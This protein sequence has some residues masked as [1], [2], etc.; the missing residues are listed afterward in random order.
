MGVINIAAFIYLFFV[1]HFFLFQ[2]TGDYGGLDRDSMV[3]LSSST[4]KPTPH[5]H[6]I[7]DADIVFSL[8]Y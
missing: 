7:V 8:V 4:A 3:K 5:F 6:V 2:I 1:H